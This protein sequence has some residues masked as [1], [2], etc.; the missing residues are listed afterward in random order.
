MATQTSTLTRPKND[1]EKQIIYAVKQP[2]DCPH[3]NHIKK[4]DSKKK[5]CEVCGEK[6]HLRLC[7]SC[8]GVFCCESHKAHNTEHYLKTGHPIIQAHHQ[9]YRF[10]WCYPCNAYLK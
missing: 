2:S 8:G 7:T 6:N 9:T 5:A 3:K 10:T 1:E 4:T